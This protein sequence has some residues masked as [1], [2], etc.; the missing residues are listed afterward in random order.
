MSVS[1][2]ISVIAYFLR[3][4]WLNSGMSDL[5][6]LY[7]GF[8]TELLVALLWVPLC[9]GRLRNL[10]WPVYWCFFVLASPLLS[11]KLLSV[12]A[13]VKGGSFAIPSW[14]FSATLVLSVALLG[15][16]LALFLKPSPIQSEA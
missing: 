2:P 13:L 15:F 5:A 16:F 8:G 14:Y 11:P 12:V 4:K 10:Q 6:N 7:A 3:I 9:L 1:V